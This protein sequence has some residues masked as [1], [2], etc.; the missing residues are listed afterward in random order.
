MIEDTFK[1]AFAYAPALTGFTPGRVNLIGEHIDYNG[2]LVLPTA[3]EQGLTVALAP[4]DD[5]QIHITS[6]K[7]EQVARRSL[8]DSAQDH[9]S[10]YV[11]GAVIYA[12]QAG[13]LSGG[14]DVAIHTTLPFGAGLSSSAAVTV[15]VLKLARDLAGHDTTDKDI[16][17]T[18]RRIE[19]EFI[20]VPCG[21]M[22]QVA[23]AIA[24][25][26]Q[27]LALDTRSLD[28]ALIDLPKTHKMAVIHSGVFRQLN[29]GRY[30]ERKAECDAIKA[31]IGHDDIC[32]AT[33]QELASLKDLPVHIQRRARH[34]VSEHM[35]VQEA[36]SALQDNDMKKFGDLLIRGHAS[37]R[38]DFEI[39]VPDIDSLVALAVS[40]GA[41]GAR[42]TG[43]GFGGCIVACVPHEIYDDWLSALLLQRPEAFDVLKAKQ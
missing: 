22:D 32:H 23:V 33:T 42:Q 21:I 19:N 41:L 17:V 5:D 27:A 37:I 34:C 39:T 9:W 3:L 14:A 8:S 40:L 31:Q 20:G 18:A 25:P 6:D 12:H 4:R 16:A 36:V 30:A 38:D 11:T 35:R 15:G 10:D 1:T 43:G 26:G 7:F 28:Y 13:Y 24:H 2:G 29:E